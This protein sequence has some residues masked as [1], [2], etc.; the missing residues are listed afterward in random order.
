MWAGLAKLIYTK[1]VWYPRAPNKP[2]VRSAVERKMRFPSFMVY[3]SKPE[4]LFARPICVILRFFYVNHLTLT[5]F[6]VSIFNC[7]PGHYLHPDTA[8]DQ[9]P[10]SRSGSQQQALRPLFSLPC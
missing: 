10:A 3:M 1:A 5:Y 6:P 9:S 7:F 4:W 8:R 2:S